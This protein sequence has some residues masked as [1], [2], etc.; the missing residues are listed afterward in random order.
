MTW[1]YHKPLPYALHMPVP[2]HRPSLPAPSCWP[3]L[4]LLFHCKCRTVESAGNKSHK[5][6][7]LNLFPLIWVIFVNMFL[8][9]FVY[10]NHRCVRPLDPASGVR[11][12]MQFERI[13]APSSSLCLPPSVSH[14]FYVLWM[15]I[16]DDDDDDDDVYIYIYDVPDMIWLP[17][18]WWMM[19]LLW[20]DLLVDD[21]TLPPPNPIIQWFCQ[22]C[23]QRML[24]VVGLVPE[25]SPLSYESSYESSCEAGNPLIFRSC[26][27]HW[28]RGLGTKP[29]S[30]GPT[31]PHFWVRNSI[32]KCSGITKSL[33]RGFSVAQETA[34]CQL[35]FA[36]PRTGDFMFHIP[37]W[38]KKCTY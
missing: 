19:F 15:Y 36:S 35:K 9:S 11:T 26:W 1:V 17:L 23:S 22:P 31:W 16:M 27:S 4:P 28:P 24:L 7:K 32:P 30:Q 14:H 8:S 12:E 25:S 10:P 13:T 3:Q 34:S 5:K 37:R 38:N 33:P 6:L 18:F 20:Y 29:T 2:R 21:R